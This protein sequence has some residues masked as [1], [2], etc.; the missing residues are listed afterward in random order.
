MFGFGTPG[1]GQGAQVPAQ[2]QQ[3]IVPATPASLA[4]FDAANPLASFFSPNVMQQAAVPE[5]AMPGLAFPF[6]QIQCNAERIINGRPLR[7]QALVCDNG[8]DQDANMCPAPSFESDGLF[9]VPIVGLPRHKSIRNNMTVQDTAG[10]SGPCSLCPTS[11]DDPKSPDRC[12]QWVEMV[13]AVIGSTRTPNDKRLYGFYLVS[14]KNS[15][16]SELYTF[17]YYQIAGLA[18]TGVAPYSKVYLLTLDHVVAKKSGFEW[19]VFRFLRTQDD[20]GTKR[21]YKERKNNDGTPEVPQYMIADT[22]PDIL[23][24]VAQ[25]IAT[26]SLEFKAIEM[27]KKPTMEASRDI[28]SGAKSRSNQQ[29]HTPFG[30]A[31]TPQRTLQGPSSIFGGTAQVTQTASAAPK[32]EGIGFGQVAQGQVT[33][34]HQK[35]DEIPMDDATRER[36]KGEVSQSIAPEVAPKEEVAVNP[37]AQPAPDLASFM[38][39]V[40]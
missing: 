12:D 20:F 14:G 13:V 22:P 33:A 2:P 28:R 23:A 24:D 15:N 18:Q 39:N 26:N 7:L 1:N 6:P 8:E 4:T 21:W 9:V 32:F 37:A 34:I 35:L 16:F 38:S 27:L 40:D 11:S 29:V 36:M 17:W 30:P 3:Q 10:S 5:P 31:P 25:R 19:N